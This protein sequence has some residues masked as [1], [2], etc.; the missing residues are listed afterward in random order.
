MGLETDDDADDAEEGSSKQD[1]Q[2][3]G[4][5]QA[6]EKVFEAVHVESKQ[7]PAENTQDNQIVPVQVQETQ[8]V[9][10]KPRESQKAADKVPDSQT[11][12]VK[13]QDVPNAVTQTEALPVKDKDSQALVEKDKQATNTVVKAP[14]VGSQRVQ[15]I[16]DALG[17]IGQ[18]AHAVNVERKSDIIHSLPKETDETTSGEASGS[19]EDET[20]SNRADTIKNLFNAI[21]ENEDSETLTSTAAEPKPVSEEADKRS[22]TVRERIFRTSR[23]MNKLLI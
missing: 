1:Q 23:T 12:V 17:D 14:A 8:T 22:S 11:V 21:G 20:D 6:E 4:S 2:P 10:A 13:D 15:L 18:A 3:T 9:A 7:Q 5:G 19:N 16:S